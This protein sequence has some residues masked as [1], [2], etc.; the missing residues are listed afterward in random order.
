M[1]PVVAHDNASVGI[2]GIANGFQSFLPS[3][4]GVIGNYVAYS[5]TQMLIVV[6]I[7]WMVQNKL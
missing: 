2:S 1:G 7:Y 3:V 4:P 6:K 5:Y